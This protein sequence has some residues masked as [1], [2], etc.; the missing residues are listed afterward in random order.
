MKLSTLSALFVWAA[1]SAT[2][3]RLLAAPEPAAEAPSNPAEAFS[4]KITFHQKSGELTYELTVTNG[5]V[6][7]TQ[8]FGDPTKPIAQIVGGW[9]DERHGTLSL[10]IQGTDVP[11]DK[12]RAQAQHFTIDVARKDVTLAHALYGHG[13]T[14]ANTTMATEHVLDLL[15]PSPQAAAIK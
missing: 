5:K 9:F 10:L 1:F 14:A 12:W 13:L 6:S 8:H 4:G 2:P 15:E 7:G 3:G 11:D